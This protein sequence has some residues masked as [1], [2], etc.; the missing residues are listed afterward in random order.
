MTDTEK[1]DKIRKI[2]DRSSRH[3]EGVD[4]SDPYRYHYQ[5]MAVIGWGALRFILQVLDDVDGPPPPNI[6]CEDL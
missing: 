2:I 5:I 4:K 3:W 1:L 6:G